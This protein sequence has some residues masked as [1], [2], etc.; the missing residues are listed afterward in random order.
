MQG[1]IHRCTTQIGPTTPIPC[2][3][4]VS[5]VTATRTQ[6]AG[7]LGEKFLVQTAWNGVFRVAKSHCRRTIKCNPA[8][9]A[10]LTFPTFFFSLFLQT[11]FGLNN[12][13]KLSKKQFNLGELELINSLAA[14]M[15]NWSYSRLTDTLWVRQICGQK[16]MVL[17][18]SQ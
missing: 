2:P 3:G 11:Q 4:H 14:A 15:T 1:R 9:G 8:P 10:L 5:T 17:K 6:G 16:W 7:Q 13:H 12:V 18:R